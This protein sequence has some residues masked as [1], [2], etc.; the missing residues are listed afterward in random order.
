MQTLLQDLRYSVRTLLKRP[1]FAMV[2]VLTLALGIGANTAIFS[3]VNAVLLRLLPYKNADRIIKIDET[4][5]G[6]QGGG[7]LTYANFIDLYQDLSP[8]G[9]SL[10]GLAASRPWSFNVTQGNEPEQISGAQVSYQLFDILGVAPM[11]GRTFTDVEDQ[12]NAEPVILIS[13][14]LWQRRF[15]AD[16]NLIGRTIR[17][18]DVNRTVIGVMPPEFSYPNNSEVWTPLIARGALQNNRRSHLL[19]VIGRL[20]DGATLAQ[21]NTEVASVA[22]RISEQYKGVDPDLSLNAVS[23]QERLVAP[24]RPALLVLLFAVGFVLLIACANVANLLLAR[25]SSREKEMAIRAALGAG[26]GRLI[27][28]MLTESLLLAIAGGAAG[29]LL[30]LWSLDLIKA[31]TAVNIPRLN[32][33]SLDGRVLIFTLLV[34]LLTGVLFGLAPALRLSKFNLSE[35]LKEG[36]RASAGATRNRLRH[37]L[38]IA[39]I[40]MSCVLLI[41]AGLLINSFVRLLQVN[42]GFDASNLLTM[43][44]FLSPT[45]YQRGETQAEVIAQILEKVRTVPGVRSA[46]VVNALPIRNAVATTFE[47]ENRPSVNEEEPVAN[48]EVIDPDYFQTMRISLLKGRHFTRQDAAQA[49][50]V[51]IINETMARQYFADEE[52]L[53]RR[54]TMKDW[55]PPLTGEIVGVVGDVKANGLESETRPMIYWNHPQFPQIFNNLVIRTGSDPMSVVAAVKSQIWSV[56]QEQTI[57]SI[58]LMDRILADSVAQRQFYMLLLAIF[59]FVALL[60]AAVGIYGVMSYTVTQRTHEIGIRMALGARQGDVL[61][62]VVGHGLF[63]ALMGVALGLVTAYAATRLMESMLFGV[64][65]TD[66]LTFVGVAVVL[67][68]VALL[69]CFVPARRAAKVDPMVALRYE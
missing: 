29:L 62:M 12:P 68:G 48:I 38:V 46:S 28:Q 22:T 65:A 55:G 67:T 14:G 8:S 20:R 69:A 63:L 36:G 25:A 45:K 56:D 58:S 5:G 54:I 61:K 31:F 41:G 26:R 9:S 47:V 50:Q 2:A 37:A 10:E 1:G 19:T 4:H 30:A 24:I 43:S 11:D 60:L 64:T 51:M 35:S 66:P 16:P 3:V 34:S 13:H 27:R 7:Q 53:G 15:G 32:E 23:L 44:V 40:A 17:V 59:A 18:N 52:P 49:P 33:V 21:A 42:S 6:P 57:A 39:E